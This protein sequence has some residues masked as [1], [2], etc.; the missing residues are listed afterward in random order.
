MALYIIE[1]VSSRKEILSRF[2]SER[3]G[4]YFW[5]PKDKASKY[6]PKEMLAVL[7]ELGSGPWVFQPNLVEVEHEPT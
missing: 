3:R 7:V 6:T 5:V 1:E 2:V 4:H